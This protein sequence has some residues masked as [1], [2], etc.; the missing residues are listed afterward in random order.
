MKK[1]ARSGESVSSGNLN[2]NDTRRSLVRYRMVD[3]IP[4]IH[5]QEKLKAFRW[6]IVKLRPIASRTRILNR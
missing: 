5:I 1:S 3:G 6:V 2:V 4:G